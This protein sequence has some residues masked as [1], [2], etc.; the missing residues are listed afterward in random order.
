MSSRSLWAVIVKEAFTYNKGIRQGRPNC[1]QGDGSPDTAV[2]APLGTLYWD[3]TN[4]IAY[5]CEDSANNWL[6]ISV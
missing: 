1:I 6:P 4:S 3:Y 2:T 5:I